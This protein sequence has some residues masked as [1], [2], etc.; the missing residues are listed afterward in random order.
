MTKILIVL[1]SYNGGKYIKEQ[2]D[3]ILLQVD[4]DLQ[5]KVFDDQSSDN[6]IAVIN[7][8]NDPR[9][10][11]FKNEVNSGSAASNFIL[12]L[13]QIGTETINTFDYISFAD[14]DDIWL[15][16]KLKSAIYELGRN[17]AAL[18]ASN[19]IRWNLKGD[20]KKI[21]KKSHDQKRFDYLFEGG[22]AGCTYVF[23]AQLALDFIS[24]IPSIDFKGWKHLSHDWLLYFY[25]R[26]NN[27][28]VYIDYNSYIFYR[29]HDSNVHG[30]LTLYDRFRLFKEDWYQIQ[31]R[32]FQKYFLNEHANEHIIY[33]QFN[34]NWFTRIYVLTKYNFQLMRSKRKFI[35]FYFLNFFF[36][37]QRGN[38]C[39]NFD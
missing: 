26:L 12:A 34:S 18:Y 28:K 32:N 19:L 31:S 21:L 8:I 29:I 33:E 30:A 1:A 36:I 10:E 13:L 15:D 6:T 7:K 24:A 9:I 3:S 27:Y 35:V 4:V 39:R 17:D 37:K 11:V 14:Q 2:I 5:L 20:Q 23:T 16:T 22:S 38:S 25:A